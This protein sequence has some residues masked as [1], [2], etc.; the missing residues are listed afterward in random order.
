MTK[1]RNGIRYPA[2]YK[3]RAKFLRLK[4]R[5]HREIAKTLGVSPSIAHQW[6]K[7]IHITYQQKKAIEKRRNRHI[8]NTDERRVIAKRLAPYRLKY[9]NEDLLNR[10]RNFYM[11]H[12]RIPLKREFNAWDIYM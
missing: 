7:K 12:E 1:A 2:S 3:Q 11:Q 4:G 10:I 9:S 5:T 8:M 6:T